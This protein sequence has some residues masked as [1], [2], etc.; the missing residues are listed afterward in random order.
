MTRSKKRVGLYSSMAFFLS[1]LVIT[2]CSAKI[3]TDPLDDI[4][5]KG[6][7]TPE[8]YQYN[9]SISSIDIQSVDYDVINDAMQVTLTLAGS[10]DMEQRY[11]VYVDSGKPSYQDYYQVSY[12]Y[13]VGAIKTF[14]ENGTQQSSIIIED[15]IQNGSFIAIIPNIDSDISYNVTAYTIGVPS[16]DQQDTISQFRDYIPD[17][18]APWSDGEPNDPNN[19]DS[20]QNDNGSSEDTPDFMFFGLIVAIMFISGIQLIR[21]K[22]SKE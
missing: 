22:E 15:P 19:G 1:V 9:D 6:V 18:L 14:D 11:Y 17:N 12:I 13:G 10:F 3:I 2:T 5:Y 20:N 8:W 21:R 7:D 4:W 16:V